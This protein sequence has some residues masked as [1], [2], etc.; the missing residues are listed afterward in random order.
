MSV[1]PL[2]TLRSLDWRNYDRPATPICLLCHTTRAVT[3]VFR[4]GDV[5]YFSC[6]QCGNLVI[7]PKPTQWFN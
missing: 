4:T 7:V 5:I 1:D 2:A 6:S 3:V